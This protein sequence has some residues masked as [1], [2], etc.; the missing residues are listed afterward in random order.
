MPIFRV[1]VPFSTDIPLQQHLHTQDDYYE[2]DYW[3]YD[4]DS[5]WG[6]Y[7]CE[8]LFDQ[9]IESLPAYDKDV[10]AGTDDWPSVQIYGSCRS[11]EAYLM[12]YYTTRTFFSFA[13]FCLVLGT[14]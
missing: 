9:D 2:S 13:V 1:G 4:W 3:D 12:D 10:P 5:V 7:A 8:D 11:C 6:E 14:C